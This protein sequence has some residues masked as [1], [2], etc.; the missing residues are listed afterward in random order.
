MPAPSLIQDTLS[1][2]GGIVMPA[3]INWQYAR[4]FMGRF[5]AK[6]ARRFCRAELAI[7]G[8]L[9]KLLPSSAGGVQILWRISDDRTRDIR[10]GGIPGE[11]ADAH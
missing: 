5:I 6:Y 4:A 7:A 8:C 10:V 9:G 11:T 2:K 3:S 1:A